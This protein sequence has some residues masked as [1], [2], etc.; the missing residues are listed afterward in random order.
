MST[1]ETERNRLKEKKEKI[2]TFENVSLKKENMGEEGKNEGEKS[3][4]S[5]EGERERIGEGE[6]LVK[7]LSLPKKIKDYQTA[8]EAAV[9]IN[10]VSRDTRDM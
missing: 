2:E 8:S 4:K 1:R 9:I 7:V 6:S 3:G 10:L 5:R